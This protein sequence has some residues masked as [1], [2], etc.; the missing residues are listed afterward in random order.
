MPKLAKK[1]WHLFGHWSRQWF[2]TVRMWHLSALWS[3]QW[4]GAADGKSAEDSLIP[5]VN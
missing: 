2:I 3:S 4:F 1:M 5:E